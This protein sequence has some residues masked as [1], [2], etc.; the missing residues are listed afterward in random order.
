M[1]RAPAA[2]TFGLL[3]PCAA[4]RY[5]ARAANFW[6]ET[7]GL[8]LPSIATSGGKPPV[9]TM[10]AWFRATIARFPRAMAAS[11]AHFS[12]TERASL[13][14]ACRSSVSKT[15][16]CSVVGRQQACRAVIHFCRSFEKENWKQHT[17]GWAVKHWRGVVPLARGFPYYG[18]FPLVPLQGC[19]SLVLRGSSPAHSTAGYVNPFPSGAGHTIPFSEL[20]QKHTDSYPLVFNGKLY[21]F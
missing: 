3:F 17:Y 8:L 9:S 6:H 13:K 10:A 7:C 18:G 11:R 5:R 1:G 15:P 20:Q 12:S 16:I 21:S 4:R 14:I 19:V 2:T